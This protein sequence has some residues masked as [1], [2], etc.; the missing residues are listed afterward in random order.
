MRM[1]PAKAI[2]GP[3]FSPHRIWHRGSSRS[4]DGGCRAGQ[5]SDFA[6]RWRCSH[7]FRSGWILSGSSRIMM[8]CSRRF[9]LPKRQRW[10]SLRTAA[11]G[12]K[13]QRRTKVSMRLGEARQF[14]PRHTRSQGSNSKL[15]SGFSQRQHT[16]RSTQG[17]FREKGEQLQRSK[18][19]QAH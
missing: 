5:H 6:A 9:M 4:P 15:R 17:G 12:S 19:R 16:I 7:M 18:R 2:G 10:E 8:V 13:A 14:L 1:S 3:E 11:C